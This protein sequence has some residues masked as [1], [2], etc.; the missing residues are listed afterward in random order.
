[1][2]IETNCPHQPPCDPSG[3][4]RCCIVYAMWGDNIAFKK[5]A[6]DATD[7]HDTA[8]ELLRQ[9]YAVSFSN[10]LILALGAQ[11]RGAA[12]PAGG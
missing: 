11:L 12:V 10:G 7:A 4:N 8:L 6:T 1:M 3:F 9:G 2:S 5:Q